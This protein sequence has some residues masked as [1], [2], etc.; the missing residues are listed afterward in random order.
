MRAA[1]FGSAP[2]SS[3]RGC[4]SD[5][6]STWDER[7]NRER[8]DVQWAAECRLD[9]RAVPGVMRDVHDKG[10]FFQPERPPWNEP[11]ASSSLAVD[12]LVVITYAPAPT[13]S[14]VVTVAKIRWQG[15]SVSNQCSGFGLEFSRTPG[16]RHEVANAAW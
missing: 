4:E 5:M 10:T 3:A 6:D 8:V 1:E 15:H 13:T 7:R 9:G 2:G 14:R 12:D 16:A 11:E